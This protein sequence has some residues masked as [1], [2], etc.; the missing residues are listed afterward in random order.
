MWPTTPHD[1]KN[2]NVPDD[3]AIVDA[4]SCDRRCSPA[5]RRC[6]ANDDD[7]CDDD[8]YDDGD[9]EDDDDD[10]DNDD[11]NDDDDDDIYY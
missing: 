7:D 6:I 9:D 8:D 10:D 3:R 5:D 2:R 11:D 4:S 1:S